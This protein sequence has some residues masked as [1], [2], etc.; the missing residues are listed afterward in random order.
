LA[1]LRG[2]AGDY[3]R[4]L[5]THSAGLDSDPGELET[6]RIAECSADFCSADL[7]GWRLLASRS[8]RL[9]PVEALRKACAEADIV[10]SDRR[11]PA[12]C[13]PRWLKA[14]RDFLA[15]SGG[16]AITL[17]RIPEVA[18][19]ASG[20]RHPWILSARAKDAAVQSHSPRNPELAP[21]RKLVP[22]TNY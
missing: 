9:V 18:T 14:D 20:D 11:L 17:G 4:E 3:V 7:R 13:R 15:R 19:T 21:N 22:G 8:D 2:R 10:V 5:M 6:L 1:L 16:L 12:P